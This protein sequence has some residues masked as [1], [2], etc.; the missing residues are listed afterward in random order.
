MA[1]QRIELPPFS[2]FSNTPAY[3]VSGNITFGLMN[4]T[5]VPDS[6]DNLWPVP[7]SGEYRMDILSTILYGTPALWHVIASVNDLLDP[8]VGVP[9]GTVIRVP[10][11]ERLAAEGILSV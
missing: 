6:T 4:P 2:M 3:D 1:G 7:P 9:A 5:T 11:R 8:L 10:T